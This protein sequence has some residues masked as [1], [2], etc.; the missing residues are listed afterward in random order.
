MYLLISILLVC[1]LMSSDLPSIME[2]TS[3]FTYRYLAS[4]KFYGMMETSPT[5]GVFAKLAPLQNEE[6]YMKR[7]YRNFY[8][9]ILL[10]KFINTLPAI[11]P[12]FGGSISF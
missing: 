4:I 3:F 7:V 8:H 10:N 12:I 11:G 5:L 9:W 6:S 2:I 1:I